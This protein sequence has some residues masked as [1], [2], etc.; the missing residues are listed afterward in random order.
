MKSAGFQGALVNFGHQDVVRVIFACVAGIFAKFQEVAVGTVGCAQ[1]VAGGVGARCY[2]GLAIAVL[3]VDQEFQH[4]AFGERIVAVG[5]ELHAVD[6][7]ICNGIAIESQIL[8]GGG[9]KG[10][11]RVCADAVF[12]GNSDDV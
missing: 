12:A 2:E 3:Y 4:G 1:F 11:G 10:A 6:A 8:H 5:R 7:V 9:L